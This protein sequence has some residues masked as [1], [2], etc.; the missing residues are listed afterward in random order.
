MKNVSLP[1]SQ[2]G[3][4]CIYEDALKPS[5]RPS[6]SRQVNSANEGKPTAPKPYSF[7]LAVFRQEDGKRFSI[8]DDVL[9]ESSNEDRPFVA[10]IHDFTVSESGLIQMTAIWYSRIEEISPKCR[11]SDHLPVCLFYL[12]TS[13]ANAIYNT[14]LNWVYSKNYISPWIP[15]KMMLIPYLRLV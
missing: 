1:D 8:G 14:N 7:P 2:P 10:R 6:R 13:I 9:V 5:V 15:I 4:E 11:R 12:S 3:W